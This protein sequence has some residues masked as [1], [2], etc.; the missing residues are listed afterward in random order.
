MSRKKGGHSIKTN[1]VRLVEAEGISY[2]LH[3]YDAP[4]GFLDGVSVALAL[5]QDSRRVFKTLIT[6]GSSREN[7][8]CVIPVEK[9]LDLKKAAACFG[10]KKLEMI[11]AKEITK[12]TGYIKGGCSPIGMKKPFST[13]VDIS[14]ENIEWIIVSGGKVGLQMEIPTEA[15]LDMT[16]A[17]LADITAE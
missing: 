2:R 11:P 10:E 3:S 9:E 13:V 4:E 6:I 1:A 7:H 17:K 8:V 15:L 14:A 12:T 5:G 16:G